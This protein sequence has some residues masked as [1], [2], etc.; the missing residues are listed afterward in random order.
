M[1]EWENNTFYKAEF[2]GLCMFIVA[3]L[4]LTDSGH[5]WDGARHFYIG[6]WTKN[7]VHVLFF[8]ESQFISLQSDC[9]VLK[10]ERAIMVVIV[11]YLCWISAYQ[12]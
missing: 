10:Y 1:C 2:V 7:G 12:H 6:C 3:Q 4:L 5:V 11:W 8:N 9:R